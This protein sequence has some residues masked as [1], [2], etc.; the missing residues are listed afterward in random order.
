MSLR[1]RLGLTLIIINAVLLAFLS[2]SMLSFQQQSQRRASIQN[3][4]LQAR[5]SR[6]ISP[7][8]DTQTLDSLGDMLD[9]P[10][11]SQFEDAMIIDNDMLDLDGRWVAI[12]TVLNPLGR[13][14]RAGDFPIADINSAVR[15]AALHNHSVQ[16]AGGV[17][18]PLVRKQGDAGEEAWGAVYLRLPLHTADTKFFPQLLLAVI[19]STILSTI[20]ITFSIRRLIVKPVLALVDATATITPDNLPSSLP[21]ADGKELQQLT[22]SFEDLMFRINGFQHELSTEVKE[23][24]ARATDAERLVA[25]QERMSAMG[26]LAAGLAHEINSPLAGAM[27]SL[28]VLR[29]EADS[30]KGARYSDLINTALQRI[31]DLVKQMLRLSPTHVEEGECDVVEIIED[32]KDFLRQRLS[33]VSVSVAFADTT[34]L[35][36]TRGDIFPLLLNLIQNSLDAFDEQPHAINFTVSDN[37]GR[38][39]LTIED[40]GPGAAAE[41]FEHLFEPFVTTKDVGRGYGLGLPIAAA[42]MRRLGGTIEARNK[43]TGG[44][45]LQLGFKL[46]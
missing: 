35:P 39:I 5:L 45:E 29:N 6:L 44:F 38:R 9:W 10:L 31:S 3:A 27:H 8:F 17:V 15:S 2:W 12:G 21:E 42:C 20:L 11:W 30:V 28:E 34:T 7:R 33:N 32:L 36:A 16:V 19:L 46:K 22:K 43:E 25:R 18:V 40:D 24:T 23:A 4:D 13:R 1:F 41:V 14:K 37:N 26:T